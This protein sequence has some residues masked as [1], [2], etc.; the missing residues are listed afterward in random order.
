[1]AILTSVNGGIAGV[2]AILG[3]G[4]LATSASVRCS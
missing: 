4:L 3:A 1:M 2:D